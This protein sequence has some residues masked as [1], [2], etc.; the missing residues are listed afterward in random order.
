MWSDQLDRNLQV[1]GLWREGM[2]VV[3]RG[4]TGARGACEFWL[5]DGVVRG[6][7]MFD[8]GRERR[9]IEKMLVERARPEP[10]A[11]ADPATHLKAL[12]A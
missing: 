6:G 10:R 4:E 7:V 9:F 2:Q 3:A 12:A 1:V 8:A 5:E 11:L